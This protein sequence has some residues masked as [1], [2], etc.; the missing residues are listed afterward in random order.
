MKNRFVRVCLHCLPVECVPH[1]G[2][3]VGIP[4]S[5]LLEFEMTAKVLAEQ[6]CDIRSER[7]M[8]SFSYLPLEMLRYPWLIQRVGAPN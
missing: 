8:S 6:I 3:N 7:I 4:E 2:M 5:T 1:F